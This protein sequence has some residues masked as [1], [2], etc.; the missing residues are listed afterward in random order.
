MICPK[1]GANVSDGA[2]FCGHCGARL[3]VPQGAEVYGAGGADK[4]VNGVPYI[5]ISVLELILC[6][7]PAAIPAIVYSIKILKCGE[8]GDETGARKNAGKAKTWMIVSAVLGVVFTAIYFAAFVYLYR[9]GMLDS[10]LEGLM[11]V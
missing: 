11:S 8:S 4:P 6:C 10:S 5:V 7:W 1:C 2:S 3:G 9:N